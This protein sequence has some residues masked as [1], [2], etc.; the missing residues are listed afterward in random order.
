MMGRENLTEVP[1]DA[2]WFPFEKIQGFKEFVTGQIEIYIF[3]LSQLIRFHR[4]N[5]PRGFHKTI[6]AY[7]L[8]KRQRWKLNWRVVTVAHFENKR[9]DTGTEIFSI[10][11]T[12]PSRIHSRTLPHP[13]PSRPHSHSF[14]RRGKSETAI[15]S[16]ALQR[17]AEIWPLAW[18]NCNC[19]H[20]ERIP[21]E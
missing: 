14:R 9:S 7:T 18:R 5:L 16:H 20:P 3:L 19:Q 21:A 12:L 8:K 4:S 1:R 6:S 10:L 11:R 17:G 13:P 15:I 2:Y